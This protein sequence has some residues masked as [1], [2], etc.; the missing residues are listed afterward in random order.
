[1]RYVTGTICS[2]TCG[3][4]MSLVIGMGCQQELGAGDHSDRV[5]IGGDELDSA[6]GELEDIADTT[7]RGDASD[8]QPGRDTDFDGGSDGGQVECHCSAEGFECRQV[9]A[10]LKCVASTVDEGE[11]DV[12]SDSSTCPAGS[13]CIRPGL[14]VCDGG[15]SGANCQPRC[16]DDGEC[17]GQFVC[18]EHGEC[19]APEACRSQSQCPQGEFCVGWI[20]EGNLHCL[21]LSDQ[22]PVGS[23]CEVDSDCKSGF[24]HTSNK[25]FNQCFTDMDCQDGRECVHGFCHDY[26]QNQC[27]RSCPGRQFCAE[28]ECISPYCWRSNDCPSSDCLKRHSIG[29]YAEELWRIFRYEGHCGVESEQLCKGKEFRILDD[30]PFCRLTQK[31]ES[32]NDCPSGYFCARSTKLTEGGRTCARRVAPWPWPPG[33]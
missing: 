17:P 6:T 32:S 5:D 18:T 27:S 13:R 15:D 28:D 29:E 12:G 14:C 23:P 19:E 10:E 4:M 16:N 11:C 20:Y 8:T 33:E 24:C 25:C 7:A 21:D 31:C 3:L 22:R 2:L 26:R 1:M 9:F 30:D